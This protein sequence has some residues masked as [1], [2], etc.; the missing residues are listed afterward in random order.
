ML[1]A[2]KRLL[3][4]KFIS[5]HA[6]N[7]VCRE[8]LCRMALLPSQQF[9]KLFDKLEKRL[10]EADAEAPS[11]PAIEDLELPECQELYRVI[12]DSKPLLKMFKDPPHLSEEEPLYLQTM[13]RLAYVIPDPESAL[14]VDDPAFMRILRTWVVKQIPVT[15]DIVLREDLSKIVR[16]HERN[17]EVMGLL[18][19]ALKKTPL[20][21]YEQ[22]RKL[23]QFLPLLDKGIGLTDDGFQTQIAEMPAP[24]RKLAALIR[25]AELQSQADNNVDSSIQPTTLVNLLLAS[26]L[27]S[28]ILPDVIL[29]YPKIQ[30]ALRKLDSSQIASQQQTRGREDNTRRKV[31]DVLRNVP[32]SV[33]RPVQ[34]QLGWRIDVAEYYLELRKF[35]KLHTFAYRWP[36]YARLLQSGFSALKNIEARFSQPKY[37]LSDAEKVLWEEMSRDEELGRIMRAQPFFANLP[38]ADLQKYLAVTPSL[39][40]PSEPPDA[41][42]APERPTGTPAPVDISQ[43]I[44]PVEEFTYENLSLSMTEVDPQHYLVE[45]FGQDGEVLNSETINIAWD[46]LGPVFEK[47][48]IESR[49]ASRPIPTRAISSEGRPFEVVTKDMGMALYDQIFGP[50]IG[51]QLQERLR[52]A[53]PARIIIKPGA[54]HTPD[55]F[56]RLPWEALYMPGMNMFVALNQRYSIVRH[57]KATQTVPSLQVTPPLRILAILSTPSDLPPLDTES[58]KLMLQQALDAV[59]NQGLVELRFLD[60]TTPENL[61]RSL[62]L[63]RPHVL[64][65][66][67]HAGF[68]E[69]ED[70]GALLLEDENGCARPVYASQLKTILADSDLRVLVLNGCWTGGARNQDITSSVAGSLVNAGVPVV[71]ATNQEITDRAA[72]LFTREFYQAFADGYPVERALTEARKRLNIDQFEW[73]VYVLFTSTLNL[74]AM[75]LLVSRDAAI[76]K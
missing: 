51:G 55:F 46:E 57:V 64:H 22:Q 76:K 70:Q 62:R 6:W 72:L 26:P 39:S 40:R 9:N 20:T 14:R 37:D 19:D 61:M 63:F 48:L 47:L 74:E 53:Q 5:I 10:L 36:S 69:A 27:F 13:L 71:I 31:D 34:N 68:F 43:V 66:V 12:V 7:R 30:S 73:F 42:P 58:E 54:H 3:L 35:A 56:Y 44:A 1:D 59:A 41:G 65:F 67:G 75:R 52:R 2:R 17:A 23:E 60:P 4:E 15:P 21:W 24:F 8:N 32:D 33:L 45:L 49:F 38:P 16:L 18:H 50:K 25:S 29:L 11:T 28:S